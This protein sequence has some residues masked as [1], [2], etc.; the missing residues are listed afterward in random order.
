M[1]AESATTTLDEVLDSAIAACCEAMA[2]YR[3]GL[4]VEDELRDVL[5]HAGLVQHGGE[6]WLLD[7]QAR[8][9]W[10]YDGLGLGPDAVP[11]TDAGVVRLRDVVVELT[12][13]GSTR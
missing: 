11:L 13:E 4:L 5:F 6:A 10:K 9:W 2:D 3:A 12:N 1:H 8:R 7:L